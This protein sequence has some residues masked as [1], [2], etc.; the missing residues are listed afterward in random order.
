MQVVALPELVFYFVII[1][2]MFK[3]LIFMEA[4]FVAVPYFS[5]HDYTYPYDSFV[6]Q[7]GSWA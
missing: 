4:Y 2:M 3:N 5:V 7:V 6:L 1:I